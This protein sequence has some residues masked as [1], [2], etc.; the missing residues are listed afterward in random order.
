M[1]WQR[2]SALIQRNLTV[3][4]R[5]FNYLLNL[6]FWPLLDIALWSFNSSWFVK[7]VD[8]TIPFVLIM[9]TALS[10]WNV[11]IRGHI[12][13]CYALIDEVWSHNLV[14]LFSSPITKKE[15][16]SALVIASALKACFV[17]LLSFS[18]VWLMYG[19]N[20]VASV[21]IYLIPF[22]ISLFLSGLTLGIFTMGLLIYWGRKVEFIM[23]M[24]CWLF[25]PFC[26]VYYSVAVLPQALQYISAAIPMTFV[27]ESMRKVVINEQIAPYLFYYNFG[28]TVLY[29][30][31]ALLFFTYMFEKSRQKGLARL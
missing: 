20:I 15:W 25:A 17:L 9:A 18:F 21:G 7:N 28:L 4:F 3:S 31:G 8:T 27:F 13:I 30:M 22:V 29:L 10:L 19:I 1:N 12:D 11:V 14:N 16:L 5:E 24:M 6:I 23:W 2:I 26:G